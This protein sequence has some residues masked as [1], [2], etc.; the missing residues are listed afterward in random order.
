VTD[1]E[2]LHRLAC[3]RGDASYTDP[4][5]GFEVSFKVTLFGSHPRSL[6]NEELMTKLRICLCLP[7]CLLRLLCVHAGSAVDAAAGTASKLF[8]RSDS[9][10]RRRRREDLLPPSS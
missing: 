5:T 6:T 9:L 1:I 2:E 7:R 8:Q 10:P 4:A 3:V